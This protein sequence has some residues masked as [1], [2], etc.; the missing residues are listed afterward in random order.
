[1]TLVGWVL[2]I[3]TI[4]IGCDKPSRTSPG[5]PPSQGAKPQTDAAQ[6]DR[7]RPPEPPP[8]QLTLDQPNSQRPVV[9]GAALQPAQVKPGQTVTL[10]VQAQTAPSW[11]IYA[12]QNPTGTGIATSLKWHWPEGVEPVGDWSYPKARLGGDGQNLIYDGELTFRRQLRIAA[13]TRP[14]TL[15]LTGELG[16]Q[17]CDPFVCRPPATLKLEATAEVVQVP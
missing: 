8:I 17:A 1:M 2:W 4:G 11:H 5:A 15:R 10:V 3:T 9:A 6:P 12:A 13:N 16:Y 14:G 7:E